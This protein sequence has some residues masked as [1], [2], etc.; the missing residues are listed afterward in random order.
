MR[1]TVKRNKFNYPTVK[2]EPTEMLKYSNRHTLRVSLVRHAFRIRSAL[3][4][5][6]T[7]HV[8]FPEEW[9][10][11]GSLFQALEKGRVNFEGL[12]FANLTSDSPV[13]LTLLCNVIRIPLCNPSGILE[14][15]EIIINYN[16]RCVYLHRANHTN[17]SNT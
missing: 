11:F 9:I 16:V 14:L 12:F 8:N 15:A 5:S 4:I 3:E 17:S 10:S 1:L 7:F 13:F 6:S 2:Y